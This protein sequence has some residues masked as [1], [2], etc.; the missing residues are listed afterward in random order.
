MCDKNYNFI[1]S[2]ILKN[3]SLLSV[4]AAALIVGIFGN[5]GAYASDMTFATDTTISTSMTIANGETWTINSGVTLTIN[6]G[7][8]ITVENGGSIVNDGIILNSGDIINLG[9]I[10]NSEYIMN[11]VSA[12]ILNTNSLVNSGLIEN[13][14]TINFASFGEIIN[15]GTIFNTGT[16]SPGNILIADPSGAIFINSGDL[17][18]NSEIQNVGYIIVNCGNVTGPVLN[19]IVDCTPDAL[20]DE[21]ENSFLEANVERSLTGPLEISSK[22]MNDG[23]ANNDHVACK[24]LDSFISRVESKESSG[25]LSS[26]FADKFMSFAEA[27]KNDFGC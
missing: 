10:I 6:P 8:I 20:I 17:T 4:L 7:V 25:D 26:I 12:L 3:Y 5:Q 19:P 24:K 15:S 2:K 23:N 9:S 11:T 13:V 14:G 1:R 16:I 27:I 21:I 18:T 22:I